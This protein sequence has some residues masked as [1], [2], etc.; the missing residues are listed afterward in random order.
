MI[1]LVYTEMSSKNFQPQ[2]SSVTYFIIITN[3]IFETL[4]YIN[5]IN[6]EDRHGNIFKN[7]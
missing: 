6:L 7:L 2:I 3:R 5:D 1:F 4:T